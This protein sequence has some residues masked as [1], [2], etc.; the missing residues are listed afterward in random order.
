MLMLKYTWDEIHPAL[1]SSF[2]LP[3]EYFI[4][5]EP[6]KDMLNLNPG[7]QG[8]LLT[9]LRKVMLMLKNT[10]DEIHQALLSNFLAEFF[11][12]KEPLK[13]LVNLNPGW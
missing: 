7:L 4:D 9:F 5:K 3:A 2:S 6:A 12:Y 8:S 10:W 1:L 13:D 11:I